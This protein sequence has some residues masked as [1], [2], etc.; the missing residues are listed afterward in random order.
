MYLLTWQL[1]YASFQQ[2]SMPDQRSL[3]I[4]SSRKI[5][6][7][8]LLE[9]TTFQVLAPGRGTLYFDCLKNSGFVLLAHQMLSW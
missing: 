5:E 2:H 8:T 1:Q 6:G 4:K 7:Y 9:N 3:E